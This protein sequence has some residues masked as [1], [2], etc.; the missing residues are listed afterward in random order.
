MTDRRPPRPLSVWAAAQQ[1]PRSQRTTR[2]TPA[3]TAHP[4]KMLPALARHIITTFTEPGEL[5]L[6]PMCGIGTS[7]VEAAHLGRHAL[8]IEYEPRWATIARSNAALAARQGATG[9]IRILTADARRLPALAPS[10]TAGKVALVLTSPPYGKATHGQVHADRSHGVHKRDYHY[11][12]GTDNLAHQDLH[13]LLTGFQHILTGA[14]AL[15][16]PDGIVAIT[17]RPYRQDGELVD[18][19]GAILDLAPRAG[20]VRAGRAV[21]LLTGLRGTRLVPRTT[22]F[23]L[24]NTRVARDAGIPLHAVAHEDVLLL[25]TAGSG[26]DTDRP[27]R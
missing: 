9:T 17:V 13:G 19:P 2:Y 8:G 3:S 6:D 11:G 4:A 26:S 27:L 24:H 16:Q 25:C 10:D 15:L 5:V 20:L 1:H 12:P 7:C 21:A 22:F 23:A 18:L 14:A